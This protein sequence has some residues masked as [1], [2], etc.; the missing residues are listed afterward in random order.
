MPKAF[1][2]SLIGVS[3]VGLDQYLG[4]GNWDPDT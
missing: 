4:Y 3:T 1:H 2:N